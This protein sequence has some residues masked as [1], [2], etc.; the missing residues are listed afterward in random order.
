MKLYKPPIPPEE[1]PEG[2]RFSI[3]NCKRLASDAK[4]LYDAGRYSSAILLAILA[5]EEFAKALLLLNHEKDGLEVN[6]DKVKEY[7]G[8]HEIRLEEFGKYFHRSLGSGMP[9]DG[10]SSIWRS[11]KDKREKYI[12]VVWTQLGWSYPEYKPPKHW[13]YADDTVVDKSKVELFLTE[14]KQVFWKL[15]QD[16]DYQKAIQ[17]KSV[18]RPDGTKLYHIIKEVTCLPKP[19]SRTEIQQS[20]IKITLEIPDTSKKSEFESRLKQKISD[21]FPKYTLNI[22]IKKKVGLN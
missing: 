3:E 6:V 2:I 16:P 13:K 22:I 9:E 19:T 11:C 4:I 5:K 20:K 18:D 12:Y 10:F 8:Y 21:R 14:L 1:I 17:K 15:E 7:F